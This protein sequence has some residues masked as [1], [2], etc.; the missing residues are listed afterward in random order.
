MIESN[1]EA[2]IVD[3]ITTRHVIVAAQAPHAA[4]DALAQIKYGAFLS[5]AIET[6]ERGPMP[7]DGVYAMA[8][9]GRFFDMFTNEAH[10]L[11]TGLASPAEA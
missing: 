6:N 1:G 9:P 8:T 11:R 2:L 4:P 5:V 3:G 10:C 7:W